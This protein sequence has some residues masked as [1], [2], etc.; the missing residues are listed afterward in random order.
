MMGVVPGDPKRLFAAVRTLSSRGSAKAKL[1]MEV[2]IGE[3]VYA[4]R[5]HRLTQIM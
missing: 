2:Q 4:R 1:F 5:N 3:D